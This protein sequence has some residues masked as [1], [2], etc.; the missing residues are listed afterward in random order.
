MQRGEREVVGREEGGMDVCCHRCA[1]YAAKVHSAQ[2]QPFPG[3]CPVGSSGDLEGTH[4][5]QQELVQPPD[6]TPK[7]R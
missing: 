3:A 7:S 1:K 4:G 6:G 2:P 5:I